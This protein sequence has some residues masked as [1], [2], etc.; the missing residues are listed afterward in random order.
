MNNLDGNTST[1]WS[2]PSY[3]EVL[4]K[5][6]SQRWQQYLDRLVPLPLVR[7]AIA[8]GMLLLYWLRVWA[9]E[10]FY[11]VT[12]ALG[13]FL[14]HLLIGFL[15]PL[16]DPDE[17][18][19]LP[20]SDSDEFRPFQRRLPEYKFWYAVCKAIALASGATLF[21]FFDVPVFWPILLIY[22]IVLFFITMKKQVQHM[23]KYKYIP[24]D[25]RKKTYYK[26]R[27]ARAKD[28]QPVGSS[29]LA[30]A[31]SA[32]PASTLTRKLSK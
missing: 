26:S 7:W 25:W 31:A 10:G 30:A 4:L 6:L 15:S 8:C 20:T 11:I 13:I 3:R 17:G 18:P 14:L 22:F 23:I 32:N 21:P 1:T 9:L 28:P 27:R 24:C 19:S 2:D 5:S 29:A 16:E 12:Y